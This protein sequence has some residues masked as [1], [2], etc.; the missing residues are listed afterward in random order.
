MSS[1]SKIKVVYI[2]GLQRSGS[3]IL[4]RV[5]GS[6]RGVFYAGEIKFLPHVASANE[7]CSCGNPVQECNVWSNIIKN[8]DLQKLAT[9]NKK[10]RVRDFVT[11]MV[12]SS[13]DVDEVTKT[14]KKIRERTGC[15]TIVD[16]SKFPS[17]A[18][19]LEM[20]DH[21]DISV[22]HIVRDPKSVAHSWWKRPLD[23]KSKDT[24]ILSRNISE[25]LSN[26]PVRVSLF[27]LV[28]NYVLNN[29]YRTSSKYTIIK[30]SEFCDDPTGITDKI[31]DSFE[32]PGDGAEWV[33]DRTVN[34]KAGHNIWGN[35]DRFESGDVFI[36]ESESEVAWQGFFG[37]SVE[38]IISGITY[39]MRDFY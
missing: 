14:Y 5:L 11:G 31:I 30:F 36:R 23:D 28:W 39:P 32:L 20:S 17:Y 8:I 1:N 24:G 4:G 2:G 22:I 35:P 34:L 18:H 37:S 12:D 15:T 13:F 33:G 25:I 38:S 29:M 26:N 16:S 7:E 19:V 10:N 9:I 3:T 21:I 6:V 27:W